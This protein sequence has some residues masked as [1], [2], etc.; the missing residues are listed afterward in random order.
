MTGETQEKSNQCDDDKRSPPD[1]L[2]IK[3]YE[4]STLSSITPQ[5]TGTPKKIGE[6]QQSIEMGLPPTPLS[7]TLKMKTKS[8]NSSK[9]SH[10]GL[11]DYLD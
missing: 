6:Q 3:E 7:Q 10:F 4:S 1:T 5:V 9:S 2:Q 8:I 11:S